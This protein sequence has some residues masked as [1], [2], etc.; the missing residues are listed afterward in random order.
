MAHGNGPTASRMVC[1]STQMFVC[2]L[3][4]A[5]TE[6]HT[7]DFKSPIVSNQRHDETEQVSNL[8]DNFGARKR[9]GTGTSKVGICLS[10]VVGGGG[11]RTC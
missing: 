9:R 5:A 4:I 3:N 7:T 10:G 1:R 6:S 2:S 11:G 8:T